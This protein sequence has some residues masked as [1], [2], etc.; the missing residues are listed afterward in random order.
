M[1]EYSASTAASLADLAEGQ[2]VLPRF[3]VQRADGLYVLA[4]QLDSPAAFV[5]FVNRVIEAGLYFRNLDYSRFA[6]LLYGQAASRTGEEP[7][8]LFLASGMIPFRSERRK[9]YQSLRSEQDEA[10]FLFEPIHAGDGEPDHDRRAAGGKQDDDRVFLDFDEF[11]ASAWAA[12]VRY[13][14]DVEAVREGIELGKPEKRVVARNLP[15]QPGKDA[16]IREVAPG[17]HRDNAPRRM[18]GGKVDL[19]Q[20]ETRYP[21]VAAGVRLVQKI[22]RQPGVDGRTISGEP[23]PAPPAKDFDL[24]SLAGPGTQVKREKEAEFLVSAV[25]GFLSIDTGS[26]QFSVGDKIVSHEGVSA[27]TTGDL[28]LTGEVY[29]QHGEIQEQRFVRCRSIT[30]HADVFGNIQSWGGTVYLKHNLVG[31]SAS[32]EAGDIVVDGVASGAT[33][34]ALHGCITLRKADNCVIHGHRVVVE[35]ATCCTIVADELE[36]DV[37]ESSAI[38]SR[39]LHVRLSRSRRDID[40]VFLILVPDLSAYEEQ[41]AA[42]QKKREALLKAMAAE[43]EKIATLRSD[44]ALADYL[45]L[46]EKLRRKELTLRPEQEVSW[47]RLAGQVAPALRT[48]SQLTQAVNEMDAEHGRSSVK[49]GELLA[50]RDA[51]CAGIACSVDEV[52]DDTRISTLLCRSA[53]PPLGSLPSKDLKARLRRTDAATRLLFSGATGRFAWTYPSPPA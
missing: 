17:L 32:N 18:I 47:R 11:V 27:R 7:L 31:G 28:L 48:M 30:A 53:D 1:P 16:E 12:G 37:S 45:R 39:T 40:N 23:V 42:L 43:R 49:L 52:V 13:G 35:Q 33:L 24:A 20:F 26:N 6:G 9:L 19:R 46:A 21:Q 36:V 5:Q 41:I 29:E 2:V 50:E 51:S 38:A 25:C 22:P 34:S 10:S 4:G 15:F 14:I 44:K 3:V 8:E